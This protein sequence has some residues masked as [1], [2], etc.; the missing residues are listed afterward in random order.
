MIKNISS[1]NNSSLALDPLPTAKYYPIPA[2][3][4]DEAQYMVYGVQIGHVLLARKETT[5]TLQ[6][7]SFFMEWKALD[8][9]CYQI[10]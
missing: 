3:R 9:P 5:L 4:R 2:S 7:Q 1:E 8:Q 10:N 6:E